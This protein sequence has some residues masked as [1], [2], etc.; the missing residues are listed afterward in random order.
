MF[1]ATI[2]H[3]GCEWT[4][5]H[6]AQGFARRESVV[7]FGT[8]LE[9]GSAELNVSFCAF[10]PRE[11][12]ERAIAVP[13]RVLSGWIEVSGPDEVGVG[14]KFTVPSGNYRLVAAQYIVDDEEEVIDL[15]LEALA[16]PSE[17]SAILVA[18][19]L[20]DPQAMLVETAEVAA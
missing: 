3:P 17:R 7:N 20:L 4:D 2:E 1:D 15:F 16:E 5:E 19:E 12:Y 8:L 18:D 13:F 9:F 11:E 10:E 14:R 6:V